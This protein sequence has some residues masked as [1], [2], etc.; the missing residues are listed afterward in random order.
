M[1]FVVDKTAL[2]EVFS[3]YFGFPCQALHRL[4]TLITIIRN[5]YNRPFSG[6]VIVDSVPLHIKE[7]NSF[8]LK[9]NANHR[10]LCC[11]YIATLNLNS[12]LYY[13]L[14][15]FVREQDHLPLKEDS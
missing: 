12:Q 6:L 8:L 1:G 3:E 4:L 15:A 10:H 9:V 11:L 13:A 7:Q 5:W 2:G 14:L